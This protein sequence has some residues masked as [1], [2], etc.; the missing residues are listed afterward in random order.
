MIGST[1]AISADGNPD[2]RL[3]R[4]FTLTQ[5]AGF[6]E[7]CDQLVEPGV[8]IICELNF[9]DRPGAHGAHAHRGADDIGFLDS[10]IENAVVTEPFGEGRGFAEDAAEASA[11]VLSIQQRF[12][13]IFHDLADGEQGGIYHQYFVAVCG[14]ADACF[15]R[16]GSRGEHMIGYGGR[17]GFGSRQRFLEGPPVNVTQDLVVGS[18]SLS[19][20]FAR[21]LTGSVLVSHQDTTGGGGLGFGTGPQNTLLVSLV[22]TF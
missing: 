6:R 1:A 9:Y 3:D 17:V 5:I 21:N 14:F 2:K 8:N 22:K 7:F 11:D 4:K 13:M 20:E 15:F 19:Y 12:R 18:V 16:Y 10:G